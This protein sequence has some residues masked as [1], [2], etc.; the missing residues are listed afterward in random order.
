M[1]NVIISKRVLEKEGQLVMR[2]GDKIALVEIGKTLSP[3][4]LDGKYIWAIS[5]HD[6]DAARDLKLTGIKKYWKFAGQIE[7]EVNG[8]YKDWIPALTTFVRHFRKRHDNKKV[9]ENMKIQGDIDP[10]WLLSFF[11]QLHKSIHC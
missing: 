4:D 7:K 6:I 11:I 5:N 9:T 8:L 1:I 2:N 3:I 10:K